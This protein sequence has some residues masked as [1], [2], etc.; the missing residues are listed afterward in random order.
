ML[1]SDVLTLIPVHCREPRVH[2]IADLNRLND[3]FVLAQLIPLLYSISCFVAIVS[4]KMHNTFRF[5]YHILDVNTHGEKV[6]CSTPI[7]SWL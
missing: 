6:P 2:Q 4:A 7:A 3:N 1:I 5:L